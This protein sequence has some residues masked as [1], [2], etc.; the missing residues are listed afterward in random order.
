M[1]A[2][3]A[4]EKPSAVS[5]I[6]GKYALIRELGSGSTGVVYE[7]ENL[8]VGKKVALKLMR[9][10]CFP[11]SNSQARFLAEARAAARISH[12]NVVDI[13]DLGVTQQGVPFVVMELLRGETLAD[14]MET[15]GP[16]ALG[17]ACELMLQLLAGLSA[18]HAQGIVHGELKPANIFVTHP[19]PDRPHVK[20]LDFGIAPGVQATQQRERSAIPSPAYLAPEQVH[21]E[22]ADF[23]TDIYQAGAVLF[24]MLLG[25]D[26]FEAASTRDVLEL[27][28]AGA[29]KDL[30]AHVPEL[31]GELVAVIEEAMELEPKQ[32]IQSAEELAE[33]V[34]AFVVPSHLLSLA[35]AGGT[36]PKPMLIVAPT[37]SG[38]GS[39]VPTRSASVIPVDMPRVAR[40]NPSLL[41]SPRIPRAPTA[42]KLHVGRDFLP[43]PGDPVYQ[44]L[45]ET[46]R[47]P[48]HVPHRP[49]RFRRDVMPALFAT[50]IG[51]GL[52]VVLAWS[53]GLL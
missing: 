6:D 26:P 12:A 32:R 43:M 38:S 33:R 36:S 49:S 34:R 31:P 22:H 50:A 20:V 1:K 5:T 18:A 9:R 3:S 8:I 40:V 42:P 51:F 24:A 45:A 11:D 13:H 35:P 48:T 44:E 39:A 27:I 2:M 47:A 25:S 46:H 16:L 28:V 7:A 4:A 19:R 29:H 23:R 41:V 53:A 52:G 17:F 10:E 37:P 21:G 30:Q 14:M 15:R